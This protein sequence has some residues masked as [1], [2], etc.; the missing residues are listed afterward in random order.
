MGRPGN[1][2]AIGCM[3]YRFSIHLG[4][5]DGLFGA[6]LDFRRS[7]GPSVELGELLCTSVMSPG[8]PDT[9]TVPC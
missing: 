5:P 8:T 1:D 3:E 9:T 7:E 4:R 2:R 6:A